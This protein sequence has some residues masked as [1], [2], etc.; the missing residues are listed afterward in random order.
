MRHPVRRRNTA[1]LLA[2]TS[3]ATLLLLVALADPV[4][5]TLRGAAAMALFVVAFMVA[6]FTLPLVLVRQL[7]LR[8]WRR[9]LRGE[10]VLARWTVLPVEWRRTREV[11]REMEERPGFGAKNSGLATESAARGHGGGDAL[12]HPASVATSTPSPRSW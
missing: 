4:P 11:L 2:L 10:A 8:P 6:S 9:L 3:V 1:L 12:R 5:G 7:Q